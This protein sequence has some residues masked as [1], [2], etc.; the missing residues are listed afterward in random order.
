MML[1]DALLI[2]AIIALVIVIIWRFF[3]LPHDCDD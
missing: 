2:I 1:F 3:T